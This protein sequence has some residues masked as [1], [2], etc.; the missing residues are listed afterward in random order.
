M[1]NLIIAG[2]GRVG[3]ELAH[4]VAIKGHTV[5]IIDRDPQAFQRLEHEFQGRTLQGDVRDQDVL[6]RAGIDKADGFAA[7]TS[8]DD[9]NLV[10]AHTAYDLYDVPNVV[11]RVFDPVHSKAFKRASL[12]TVIAS[13][14]IA[15]RIEQLLTHPGLTEIESLGNGEVLLVEVQV[16]NHMAGKL[17][18]DISAEG[19]CQPVA[20]VRG[21]HAELS[22]PNDTLK[23]GDLLVVA[24]L[25]SN[26]PQLESLLELKGGER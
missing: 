14:W 26:L 24:V 8:N 3:S 21:G 5:V 2:C 1:M 23:D 15:H 11:A 18:G 7:V 12:Q 17:V 22:E 16:L 4:A 25:S 6:S 20:L 19:S 10:A 9:I 13:S